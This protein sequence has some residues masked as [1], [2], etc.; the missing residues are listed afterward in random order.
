MEMNVDT[1]SK[2]KI[3]AEKAILIFAA[4]VFGIMSIY[5]AFFIPEVPPE[6]YNSGDI[7]CEKPETNVEK[8]DGKV[9]LNTAKRQ[10]LIE[11]ILG[12]GEKLASRIVSYRETYGGFKNIEEIMN[13]KGIGEKLFAKI[14]DYITA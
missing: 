5:S 13:I 1:D 7:S 14:K 8:T 9:N 6:I 12:I 11:G 4:F 3:S 2:K 10:E